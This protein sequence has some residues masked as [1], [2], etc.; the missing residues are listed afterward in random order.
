MHTMNKP[1]DEQKLAV[2][3]ALKGDSFKIMAYA[4]AGKTSTLRLIG[5]YALANKSLDYFNGSCLYDY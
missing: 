1:T 2:E 3:Q 5:N 4:G